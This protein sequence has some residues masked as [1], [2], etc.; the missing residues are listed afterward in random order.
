MTKSARALAPFSVVA[1]IIALMATGCSCR[2]ERPYTD[3]SRDPE[4]YA[5]RIK[6]MIL[7]QL[8]LAKTEKEEPDSYTAS[9]VGELENYKNNPVG[10]YGETYAKLLSQC[11]EL[12]ELLK[13]GGDRK[14]A[15]AKIDE[16]MEIANQLPGE[17]PTD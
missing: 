10:S 12:H 11:Q 3:D 17:V 14:P 2:P 16:I 8:P 13:Q 15:I 4:A 6:V 1:C 9:V 7:R 5:R